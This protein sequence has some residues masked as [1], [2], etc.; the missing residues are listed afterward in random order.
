M[1]N[2]NEWRKVV[3]TITLICGVVETVNRPANIAGRMT[4]K[5]RRALR[6]LLSRTEFQ[7]PSRMKRLRQRCP[8]AL[9]R[10]IPSPPLL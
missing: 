9:L 1:L 5:H 3:L 4:S 8:F 7:R 2:S 6:I 10:A